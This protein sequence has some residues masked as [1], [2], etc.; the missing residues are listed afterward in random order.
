MPYELL[1]EITSAP[2]LGSTSESEQMYLITVARAAEAGN[3]GPVSISKIADALGVSV[4]S[5][6]EM[7]RKLDNRGLLAYEP[8]RG[9]LLS[10]AG[11]HIADQVLRTRRL[12]ATFLVENLG[13]SPKDADDQACH[14]EHATTPEA[15]DRL[16]VFLGNPEAGPLGHRIPDV[17]ASVRRDPLIRLT[18]LP[19]GR[20]A[21]VI[22]VTAADRT[23]DFLNTEGITIGTRITVSASG[24]SGLLVELDGGDAHLSERLATT[25]EVRPSGGV[26]AST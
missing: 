3:D 9:V 11:H 8:Y 2:E 19:V 26:S 4:P 21:E 10:E 24:S 1:D 22:A 25:I 23:L 17:T 14:L 5:A 20:T 6:N 16:A 15:A 12:W 18:D 13:F 7:V